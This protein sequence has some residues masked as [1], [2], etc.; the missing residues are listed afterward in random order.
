MDGSIS[1]IHRLLI[2]A[3]FLFICFLPPSGLQQ[4]DACPFCLNPPQ[5]LAEQISRADLVLIA[6]LVR[7][8][9]HDQGKTPES[10]LRIREYLHGKQIATT[11]RELA[12]GQVIVIRAEAAGKVG[13]LFLMFGE[14]PESAIEIADVTATVGK[15]TSGDSLAVNPVRAAVMTSSAQR[16]SAW[17]IEKTSLVIP[18]FISWNETTAIT[19]AAVSYLRQVPGKDISQPL[20]LVYFVRF[21]EHQDPLIAIDAWAEFGCS[22]YDDVVAVQGLMSREKLR[23]WIA[24][25]LM[26][27]E[28]LG[29]YGM[30]LGLCGSAEDSEFLLGQMHDRGQPGV[31]LRFG[32]EGLMAGYLLRTGESGLQVLIETF[33]LPTNVPDTASHAFVQA[34]QFM[35]SYERDLISEIRI[36]EAMRLLLRH[37]TMREIAITNLSR[38]EDWST[39]PELVTMFDNECA[40]DRSAQRAIIQFAQVCAKVDKAHGE[41]SEYATAAAQFIGRVQKSRPELLT[42]PLYD[43]TAPQ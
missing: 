7:F 5:T 16:P 9:V 10:T 33:V 8:Q 21:L 1:T 32:S 23:A 42:S 15:T 14:I 4:S 20:R 27:P 40:D 12:I 26:S 6:E 39:L 2:V 41:A 17:R 13:D 18:E 28:R 19:P 35:W 11:R 3:G 34:L 25:P 24:D 29:L 38:W 37:E 31:A 43:F 30:M 36:R 22:T